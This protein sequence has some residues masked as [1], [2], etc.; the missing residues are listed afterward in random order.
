MEI[1]FNANKAK[2]L[3]MVVNEIEYMLET[4]SKCNSLWNPIIKSIKN[5]NNVAIITIS[6]DEE[7]KFVNELKELGY[8]VKI[9]NKRFY[10]EAIIKW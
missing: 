6:N 1:D 2:E 5:C 3:T 8:D 9:E 4:A 7:M 10:T